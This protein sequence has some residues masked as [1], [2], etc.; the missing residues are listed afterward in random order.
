MCVCVCVYWRMGMACNQQP[1]RIKSGVGVACPPLQRL[2]FYH[3]PPFCAAK[4]Q[5]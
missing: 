2:L 4:K 5:M 3:V 1:N